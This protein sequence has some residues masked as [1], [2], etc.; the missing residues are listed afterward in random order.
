MQQSTSNWK[1]VATV[2]TLALRLAGRAAEL[3]D[4]LLL[5][6]SFTGAL[7]LP[8]YETINRSLFA[9]PFDWANIGEHKGSV[10]RCQVNDN[11]PYVP[12]SLSQHITDCLRTSLVVAILTANQDSVPPLNRS[13]PFLLNS[14][15]EEIER[16]VY[17]SL[18]AC[19]S[20]TIP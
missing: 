15:A 18:V 16:F 8:T 7:G 20:P 9:G 1:T 10:R 14:P 11:D 12:L 2:F 3:I 19:Y 6:A 5:A 4:G 13:T 17:S